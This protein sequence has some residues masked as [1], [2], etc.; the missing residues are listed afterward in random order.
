MIPYISYYN[1]LV[2]PSPL[3]ASTSSVCSAQGQ[4]FHCKFRHQVCSSAQRQ[5]STA[6]SG[7]KV[8]VLPVSRCFLSLASEQ[9]L[10][11]PRGP[12]VEVSSVDLAN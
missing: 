7:T 10:K 8:A 3:D 5:S 1:F 2:H 6:N 12:S 4:V 11:D 9:T